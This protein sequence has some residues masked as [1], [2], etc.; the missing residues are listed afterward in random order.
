MKTSY[1]PA[2]TRIV[3]L[4][5]VSQVLPVSAQ[6]ALTELVKKV[7]PSVVLIL[8][9]D[10]KGESLGQGS[11]FFVNKQGDIITN[12]HVLEKASRAE[13]KTTAEK[14]YPIKGVIAEDLESDL[15]QVT[16]EI[17]QKEV[18]P[19]A[20]SESVPEVGEKVVVIGNPLGLEHTVSDGIISAVREVP[21]YG[22][23]IQMTAP[24]SPG[25]SGSPVVNMK[26][27]VVG[28]ATF[29]MI[30]GQNLNF[31]IPAKKIKMKKWE[32]EKT[33]EEWRGGIAADWEETAEG[34]YWQGV[35]RVISEDYAEALPFL[36]KAVQ[37]KP[38]YAE[39]YA[40]IGVCKQSLGRYAQAIESYNR[41]IRIDPDL[42]D[43][44]YNLGVLY[45]NL[46]RYTAEIEAYKQAI[47]IEPDDALI[48]CN[49]G[50]AYGNL[51][52]DGEAIHA[53]KQAIRINPMYAEAY[54]NL[55]VSYTK[56]GQY[57]EAI[58]YYKQAIR[59]QP[60]YPLAHCNLGAAYARLGRWADATECHKQAIRNQPDYAPAHYNLG[61]AYLM[62]G[63]RGMAL[64]EYKILKDLDK[65]LANKLF[66]M[67]YK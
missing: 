51:G 55:G 46:G 33:F 66:N 15:I 35:L 20:V 37:K 28:V 34:S 5:I 48:Y 65:D 41:A 22:D 17:P 6:E 45:G 42:A 11:G 2:F 3:V 10:D 52:R 61:T 59:I 36:E 54:C 39:A 32:K 57:T 31:V 62:T 30:V 21:G 43:V 60:D 38:D 9:Y 23:V 13:I 12:R 47:R 50:V 56:L 14:V 8:T 1:L 44:Y 40:N 4:F 25:S 53:F 58:G 7:Q 64:E 67:I 63:N 27:E 49:L 18:F 24:M 26:G 16:L 19:I 29:Q